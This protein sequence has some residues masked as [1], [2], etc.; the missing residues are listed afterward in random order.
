MRERIT[1]KCTVCGDENYINTR[2][3]KLHTERM[4]V[5][6]YCP[7]CNAKTEHREKK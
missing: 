7:K 5:K 1:L 2:N 4:V 3:K 6:K